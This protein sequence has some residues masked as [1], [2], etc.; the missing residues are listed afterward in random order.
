MSIEQGCSINTYVLFRVLNKTVEQVYSINTCVLRRVPSKDVE[1][2]YSINTCVLR[3]VPSS[4][5]V[6]QR[7]YAYVLTC[8]V[9]IGKTPMF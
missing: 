9:F 7:T 3:R 6:L 1:Q 8:L 5:Y 2:V 4:K